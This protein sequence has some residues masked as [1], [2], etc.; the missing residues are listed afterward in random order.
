MVNVRVFKPIVI[1]VCLLLLFVG[2]VVAQETTGGLAG[3]VKDQSGASIPNATITATTS[4]LVGTKT[5]QTDSSGYFRLA[6]LP[7]GAY[8]ITITATGFSTEKRTLTIEVG[9]LPTIDVTLEVGKTT[10]VVEVTGA[11]PQIDTTTNV[12]TT[13]VTSDVIDNIPQAAHFNP[14]FSLLLRLAMNP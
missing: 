1:C 6:N 14:L 12:T 11:A 5:I 10:S 8:T 13:N 3:T 4:D 9:H 7:P 2:S